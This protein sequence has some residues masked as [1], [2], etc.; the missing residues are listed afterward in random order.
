ML[1]A[2]ASGAGDNR[3]VQA[4]TLRIVTAVAVGAVANALDVDVARLQADVGTGGAYLV[5]DNALRVDALT[6]LGAVNLETKAGADL[7]VAS[8]SAVGQT[9]TLKSDGSVVDA[10]VGGSGDDRDVIAETL[11][12]D[13]AVGLG[14]AANALNVDLVTLQGSVG[15]GGLHLVDA[16]SLTVTTLSSAGAVDLETQA[17]GNLTVGSIAAVGQTVTLT[18]AGSLLDAEATGTGDDRDVTATTLVIANATAA[19]G[20]GQALEVDIATLDAVVGAGGLYLTDA[21]DLFLRSV[22]SGGAVD[23]STPSAGAVLSV[24]LLAADGQAVKLSSGGAIVD[25]DLP[26]AGDDQDIIAGR[27]E[28]VAAAGVGGPA[29]RLETN[30]DEL[31]ASTGSGGLA[32]D[33]ADDVRIVGTT[34]AGP[35][36]VIAP[37][38]EFVATEPQTF[39]SPISVQSADFRVDA[40]LTGSRIQVLPPVDP[41]P[42]DPNAPLLLPLVVG[43]QVPNRTPEEGIFVDGDEV[44]NLVFQDIVFG[45]PEAGTQVWLQTDPSN[46]QDDLV[47]SGV[48]TV[49]TP[50][51]VTR[52]A[53]RIEGVGMAIQGRGATTYLDGAD[54]LHTA[55]VTIDDALVVTRDSIIE[56]ADADPAT[57][58]VLTIQGN[59]TVQA[60]TTLKLLADEIRFD[61]HSTKTSAIIR[62]EAGATLVIGATTITVD[63]AVTFDSDGGHVQLRGAP[64]ANEAPEVAVTGSDWAPV[65]DFV[66][67]DFAWTAQALDTRVAWL[68]ADRDGDA[69]LASLTIGADESRTSVVTPTPWTVLQASGSQVQMRGTATDLGTAGGAAWSFAAET[70]LR[71]ASGQLNVRVDLAGA[72]GL[73]LTA[74][75][76]ALVMDA[77]VVIDATGA[78]A[79]AAPQGVTVSRVTSHARIDAHSAG[80]IVQATGAVTGGIHLDAP[81]VSVHGIGLQMPVL[82]AAKVPVA[83]ADRVQVS[84]VRGMTFEGRG[85]DGGVIYRTMNR[86]V[87]FEQLRMADDDAARVLVARSDL[88]GSATRI[89]QGE[90]VSSVFV[91]PLGASSTPFAPLAVGGARAGSAVSSYLGTAGRASAL[92]WDRLSTLGSDRSSLDLNDLSYGIDE[93]SQGRSVFSGD[94][95]SPLLLSSGQVAVEPIWTIETNLFS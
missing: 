3:D 75:Q 5:D 55:D 62:L 57:T 77:G 16:N 9:V 31:Q 74:Q 34:G 59:I 86:G 54:V 80:G 88:L 48:L 4:A 25:G 53:G 65:P 15:A 21:T 73:S 6:S 8:I 66:A 71:A 28:L 93:G 20:A 36:D 30:V 79:L 58:L 84:G 61:H 13:A 67:S 83:Q 63:Q 60:G 46:P 10:E 26:G 19:G 41:T 64:S 90:S 49:E 78:V 12:V 39:S 33:E 29:A 7:T 70:A 43:T 17:S 52:L 35:I 94:P 14:S 2:E 85:A 38:G 44:E 69:G 27:L 18:V 24:G 32:L 82:D 45:G 72:A 22:T 95:G 56:V 76:G 87:A 68:A 11:L 37:R 40:T 47:F 42:A 92:S 1:D 23:V 91:L 51:G 50:F 89:G 81:S